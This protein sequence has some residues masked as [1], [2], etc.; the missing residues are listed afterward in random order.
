MEWVD[1]QPLSH[2]LREGGL[3]LATFFRFALQIADALEAAHRRDV[4]HRDVKPGNIMVDGDGHIK[5]LDF[6]LAKRRRPR[7]QELVDSRT[8]TQDGHMVGTLP[9][10]S[11]EQLQGGLVDHRTDVFSLGIVLFEMATGGRPFQGDSW[12]DLASAILRDDPPSATELRVDLPRHLGRILR[13]CLEKDVKRRFQ[14]VLDLRNE[15]ADL[16]KELVTGE[17]P[18]GDVLTP[19]KPKTNGRLRAGAWG[20][21][22][23]AVGLGA[24]YLALGPDLVTQTPT[25]EV[26]PEIQRV[27]VTPFQNLGPEDEAYFATGIAEEISSR[28]ARISSLR[29]VSRQRLGASDAPPDADFLLEGTVR[30]DAQQP[31]SLLRRVRVTPRLIRVDDGSQLW[32]QSYERVIDD[33]F[34]VQSE[35]AAE[36]ISQMDIAVLESERKALSGRSTTD[37][38]AYRAYLQGMKLAG[39]RNPTSRHW[40]EAQE[41]FERAV[42]LD[43]GFAAAWAELSEVHSLAVQLG[44]ERSDG[45]TDRRREALNAAERALELDGELPEAHRALAYYHYWCHRDYERALASFRRAAEANPN[46]PQVLA[47]MAF[48]WRRQGRFDEAAGALQ[49]ALDL[50]P[51]SAWL[52]SEVADTFRRLRRYRRADTYY[53]RAIELEPGEPSAFHLRCVNYLLWRGDLDA[54]RR[55]LTDMPQPTAT[56]SRV[57]WYSL[58]LL[59][60]APELALGHLDGID[61]G[62][63]RSLSARAPLELIRARVFRAS[64]QP[65]KA[66][67]L[68]AAA[69]RALERRLADEGDDPLLLNPLAEVYAATGRDEE[70]MEAIAKAV[71]MLPVE[72]D[73]V[74]GA[75]LMLDQAAVYAQL[76]RQDLAVPILEKVLALPGDVS[77]HLLAL[78]PR[79]VP[80]RETP[81][82]QRLLPPRAE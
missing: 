31:D 4:I 30:W 75:A 15:L 64:G 3:D 11:P 59:S 36:V 45:D 62:L 27:A 7:N 46:D 50:S 40:R 37:V 52:A 63:L 8:L 42:E 81:E 10:M 2:H 82:F 44:L 76:D 47:G 70:S 26:R 60:G 17:L 43:P 39:R 6:G 79:W 71:R 23:V 49:T 16:Q 77:P 74:A 58:E 55:V 53:A 56:S 24:G 66:L 65:E 20:A 22:L 14:T 51:D 9:Y 21:A 5:V 61:A 73:A 68:Y 78:E 57:I 48:I 18:S 29:I 54:C 41:R 12:G 1:G 72:D 32:S 69:T 67:P 13:H 28:L 35:I 33:I 80:I 34:A 38:A 19:P 25:V